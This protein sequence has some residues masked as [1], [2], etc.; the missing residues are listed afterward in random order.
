M[1]SRNGVLCR[2]TVDRANYWL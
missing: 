2:Q 1:N